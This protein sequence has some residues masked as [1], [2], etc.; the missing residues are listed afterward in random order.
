LASA[1]LTIWHYTPGD[2]PWWW[3]PVKEKLHEKHGRKES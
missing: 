2:S 3:L 1:Y